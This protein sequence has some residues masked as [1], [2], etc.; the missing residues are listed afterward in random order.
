MK[1]EDYGL[2]YA[3]VYDLITSH[4]DYSEETEKLLG[5]LSDNGVSR[6]IL[7]IGCG[8]GSHESIISKFGYKVLG[9]DT[10]PYMIKKAL[11][12]ESDNLRFTSDINDVH[13]F[14]KGNGIGCIVSLFNVVNCLHDSEAL[15][16]FFHLIFANLDNNGLFIFEAWNRDEVFLHPPV[17][18][19]RRFDFPWGHLERLA[20]PYLSIKNSS[21]SIG[22][23]IKGRLNSI[24]TNI[25]SVHDL[26][27]FGIGEIVDCLRLVGFS[28]VRIFSAL[29]E[30]EEQN[31][32]NNLIRGKRMLAFV[33]RR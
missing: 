3:E 7:S 4:K 27:L 21:L 10:S 33:A 29:P 6:N 30:F 19:N 12:R 14:F 11:E 17:V 26:K 18:V 5:F 15:L 31:P 1:N 28:E 20:T 2:D 13:K 16:S 23:E 25:T 8:T 22:Y 24:E 9:Y 32:V